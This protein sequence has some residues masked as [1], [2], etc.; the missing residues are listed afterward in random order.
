MFNFLINV[1]MFPVKHLLPQSQVELVGVVGD[2]R[3]LRNWF[4][5]FEAKWVLFQGFLNFD[6][7]SLSGFSQ[8]LDLKS[9]MNFWVRESLRSL[10]LLLCTGPRAGKIW[11]KLLIPH[12]QASMQRPA[13]CLK[14][15]TP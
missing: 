5:P 3:W 11:V 7:F 12:R 4:L 13:S 6:L 1:I 14:F 10:V 15:L 9:G 8:K 2:A